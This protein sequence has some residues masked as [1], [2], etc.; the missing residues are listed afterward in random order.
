MRNTFGRLTLWS[1]KLAYL[2]SGARKIEVPRKD[3]RKD[4]L[5]GGSFLSES[6]RRAILFAL[7]C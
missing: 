2:K 3:I 1:V 4:P 5:D 6:L 7:L